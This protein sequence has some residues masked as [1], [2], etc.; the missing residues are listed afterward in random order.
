[1]MA[2][3]KALVIVGYGLNCE[4]ETSHAL[5]LAGADVDQVHLNDLIAGK[6]TLKEFRLLALIGGF[7]FGDHISAGKVFANRLTQRLKGQLKEF[8]SSGNL[9]IG[10]CNGF[11]T[12]VKTGLLPGCDNDYSTQKVTLGQN[13]SG[14]FRNDWV[15]VKADPSSHCVFS[16][17]IDYLEVPV[18]HGEGKFVVREEGM[19]DRLKSGGQVVLRYAHPDS[20]ETTDEFPHNPNGSMDGVAGICDP[21]G[22]IFGLMPHPEAHLF[23]FNH[24][25]WLRRKLK[26]ILPEEGEGIRIFR[27]GVEYLENA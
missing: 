6:R 25:H 18:R 12:L 11:Q 21:T 14:V 22:R 20:K 16:K 1:M 3:I 2:R 9:I 5:R 10:I 7:S 4:A 15:L 8:I 13:D 19:L 24:P 27:N 17:G 23:P 26:G